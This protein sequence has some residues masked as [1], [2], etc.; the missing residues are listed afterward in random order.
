MERRKYSRIS[1]DLLGVLESEVQRKNY[2]V[3]VRDVSLKGAF[4]ELANF[5]E[6]PHIFSGQ[7]Y[8]LVI[9][10]Q[11]TTKIVMKMTC[12]HVSG[13]SLGLECNHVDPESISHLKRLVEMNIGRSDVLNRELN[14]LIKAQS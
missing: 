3:H 7:R 9:Q 11:A 10:L 13:K 1:L 8:T 14:V 4:V 5:E 6:D 2:I 12:R